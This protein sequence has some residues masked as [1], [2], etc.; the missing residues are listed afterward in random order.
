M[1]KTVYAIKSIFVRSAPGA[2]RFGQGALLGVSLFFIG[3]AAVGFFAG[4]YGI[5]P[6]QLYAVGLEEKAAAYIPFWDGGE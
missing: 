5:E 2:K 6:P 4:L 3:S 1:R